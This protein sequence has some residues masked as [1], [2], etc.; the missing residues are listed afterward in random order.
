MRCNGRRSCV[1]MFLGM[2]RN[3]VTEMERKISQTYEVREWRDVI[4]TKTEEKMK[5]WRKRGIEA[6]W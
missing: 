3:C 6:G 2:A 1:P 5:G 4:R